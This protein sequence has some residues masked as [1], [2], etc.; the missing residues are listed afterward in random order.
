MNIAVVLDRSGSMGDQH[1]IEYAKKALYS[2]IDQLQEKDIFSLVIYDDVIEVLREA[3]HV[4]N[5]RSLK[6]LVDEIYPRN[7]TNLGG[8]MAVGFRQVERYACKKY[9]NRVVLLSDGLAN[10]GITDPYELNRI[11]RQ[12]RNRSISL[13]TMGVGLEYNENL[14]SGLAES[15]G[16]NYY[17][18][19][20]PHQLASIVDK[21]FNLLR[22][23]CAGNSIIELRLGR[24]I[25]IRDVIGQEWKSESGLCTI[26]LGD[27]YASEKREVT[28]ELNIPEGT[29]SLTLAS[30][31]L[32]FEAVDA[33]ANNSPSFSS[34]LQYSNDAALIEK[35]QDMETQ[36][37]ADI[38]IS[39]RNVDCAMK[40]LDEGKQEE[41]NEA[42]RSA[43]EILSS[44]PAVSSK[45]GAPMLKLQ[46][47]RIES[48]GRLMKDTADQR[49]VKKE[50]QYENYKT[51]KN[52]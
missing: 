40:A 46:Q 41:A 1:K 12:Y 30:G 26:T 51:Q 7:S 29:G 47:D 50:I 2:L 28:V 21:E 25:V 34:S 5:K 42:L 6:A 31:K 10:Q 19:E 16:G 27:L 44:S 20:S 36:A 38:A 15:G 17:F 3:G 37:K 8:G 48:Y 32:H 45:A 43:A 24:G 49:K 52:K 11:A 39:T 35:T 13:T 18:I 23:V 22:S 14:M 4:S 33:G 9:I